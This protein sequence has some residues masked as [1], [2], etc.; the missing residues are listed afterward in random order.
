V[1][2]AVSVGY[3]LYLFWKQ[4]GYMKLKLGSMCFWVIGPDRKNTMRMNIFTV[5]NPVSSVELLGTITIPLVTGEH[6]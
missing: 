2:K 1:I 3:F 5:E 6:V 4:K